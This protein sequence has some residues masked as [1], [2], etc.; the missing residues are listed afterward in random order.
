M[1]TTRA[2]ALALISTAAL[3]GPTVALAQPASIRFGY[4]LAG[5]SYYQPY[6][7][8]EQGLFRRAG[9][10]VEL[11]NFATSGAIIQAALANAIDVGFC[12]VPGAA[13]AYIRGF[14]IGIANPRHVSV[15]DRH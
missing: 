15:Y 14:P 10:N 3:T 4:S 13:N 5:E 9:L 11:V 7:A 6:Y 2:A 8:A 1:T 12:D